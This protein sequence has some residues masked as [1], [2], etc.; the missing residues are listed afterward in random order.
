MD[1]LIKLENVSGSRASIKELR[2]LYDKIDS[3]LR[4]LLTLGVHSEHYSSMLIPI[5]V[6]KLPCEIRLQISRKIGKDN[7]KIP[8]ILDYALH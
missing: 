5:L 8:N 3:H 4:S 7:W 1:N 2:N 6:N